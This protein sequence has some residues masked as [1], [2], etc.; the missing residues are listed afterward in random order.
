MN[1]SAF[2]AAL[3]QAS[4]ESLE[5]LLASQAWPEH[6]PDGK[7]WQQTLAI[8]VAHEQWSD[9]NWLPPHKD[10]WMKLWARHRPLIQREALS[11]PEL[12]FSLLCQLKTMEDRYQPGRM[13]LSYWLSFVDELVECG[14]PMDVVDRSGTHCL[15]AL[16]MHTTLAPYPEIA[17]RWIQTHSLTFPRM[18]AQDLP[19]LLGRVLPRS[20]APKEDA[21]FVLEHAICACDADNL[22]NTLQEWGDKHPQHDIQSL[23]R[24][25]QA[26]EMEQRTS[27]PE[28]KSRERRL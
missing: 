25:G 2:V 10:E 15:L 8:R 4:P 5:R 1:G 14:M 16:L 27:V 7:S 9:E 28:I 23:L 21:L 17:S 24:L 19:G 6:L 22:S 18:K 20:S 12:M 26:M 11:G 3:N 13:H